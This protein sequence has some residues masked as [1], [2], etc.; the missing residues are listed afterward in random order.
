MDINTELVVS[1]GGDANNPVVM[2]VTIDLFPS[3][4]GKAVSVVA[5]TMKPVQDASV[6]QDRSSR[7]SLFVQH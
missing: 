3:F 4:S 6:E 7:G 2:D 1:V 5:L